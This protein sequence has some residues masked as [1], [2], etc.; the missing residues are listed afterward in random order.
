LLVAGANEV[1]EAGGVVQ[2]PRRIHRVSVV[3]GRLG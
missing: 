1:V 2:A 3:A